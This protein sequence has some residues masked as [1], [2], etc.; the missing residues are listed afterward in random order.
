MGGEQIIVGKLLWDV[1]LTF[2]KFS[3]K[4]REQIPYREASSNAVR[5]LAADSQPFSLCLGNKTIFCFP[6]KKIPHSRFSYISLYQLN[7][8]FLPLFYSFSFFPTFS[9][10]PISINYTSFIL[11]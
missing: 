4:F 10:F 1:F 6:I 11:K 5:A 7:I 2:L 9:L 8:I 3:L